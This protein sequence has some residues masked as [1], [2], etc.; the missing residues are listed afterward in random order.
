M[1]QAFR[2]VVTDALRAAGGREDLAVELLLGRIR[3]D[4]ELRDEVLRIGVARVLLAAL[5]ED[6]H[7]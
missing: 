5:E 1:A 3:E 6:D 2:H 4:P 7:G